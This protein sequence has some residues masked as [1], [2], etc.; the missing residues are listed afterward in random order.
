MLYNVYLFKMPCWHWLINTIYK[1][2]LRITWMPVLN[3]VLQV[4]ALQPSS[5]GGKQYLHQIPSQSI[6]NHL[7]INH[8]SQPHD[9]GVLWVFRSRFS[10]DTEINGNR[11][12]PVRKK[13]NQTSTGNEL[14]YLRTMQ[15]LK[16]TMSPWKST[17]RLVYIC[18]WKASCVSPLLLWVQCSNVRTQHIYVMQLWCKDSLMTLDF[19]WAHTKAHEMHFVGGRIQKAYLP[20]HNFILVR[21]HPI[22]GRER[23]K[24]MKT[25]SSV[26]AFNF[27]SEFITDRSYFEISIVVHHWS[28]WITAF[29][30]S[31]PIIWL[32]NKVRIFWCLCQTCVRSSCER[33][34]GGWTAWSLGDSMETNQNGWI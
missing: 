33:F 16:L 22:S 25:L 2:Q 12:L 20:A 27:L 30:E 28:F 14:T 13:F 32:W 11:W 10:Y 34:L 23:D 24:W 9:V 18:K 7:P 17:V 3:V 1:V 15:S 26:S 31:I 4:C 19:P 6:P 8:K 21:S 5:G 29:R